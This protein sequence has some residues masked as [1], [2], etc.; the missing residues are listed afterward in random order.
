MKSSFYDINDKN[1]DYQEISESIRRIINGLKAMAMIYH[2]YSDDIDSFNRIH[3]L[4]DNLGY[5][6]KSAEHHYLLLLNEY[7]A[8]EHEISTVLKDDPKLFEVNLVGRNPVTQKI[9]EELAAIFDSL[10]YHLNSTFDYLAHIT[11]YICMKEIKNT[12]GWMKLKKFAFTKGNEL[13]TLWIK[14]TIAKVNNEY[15]ASLYDYRSRLIHTKRDVHPIIAYKSNSKEVTQL[16][17]SVSDVAQKY[18]KKSLAKFDSDKGIS[19]SFLAS[20]LIRDTLKNIE[21]MLD[22]L[23]YEINVASKFPNNW[24]E[25]KKGLMLIQHD[26]K[27]NK[28]KLVSDLE[29][30][31]FKGKTK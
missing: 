11:S 29:W 26:P 10:I 8:K 12:V 16:Y 6:L 19:L 18:F 13:S 15:V 23:V 22:A 9:E 3:E 7:V 31:K 21:L 1:G 30:D 28:G 5:R 27:T 2:D 25:S 17:L 24:D 20:T 4:K 14:K